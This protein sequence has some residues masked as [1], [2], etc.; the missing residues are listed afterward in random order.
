[1]RNYRK[2]NKR[3]R[4]GTLDLISL[5]LGALLPLAFAP[6]NIYPIAILV[7]GALLFIWNNPNPKRVLWRGWL[8]GCGFFGV[9]ASWIFVS[10]HVYGNASVWLAGL[11]TLLFVAFLALY[12]ATQAWVYK[13]LFP[14]AGVFAWTIGFAAIWALWEWLRG[15]LFSG[16]PW[17]YLGYSQMDSPLGGF[18]P[19]IGIYG[20]TALAA[21]VGG[22]LAY[23]LYIQ[24]K[25]RWLCLSLAAL[26]LLSGFALHFIQW[27]TSTNLPKQVSLIQGNI[28]QAQKWDRKFIQSIINRYHGLTLQHEDSA[29]I[30]WPE[31]SLP[32]PLPDSAPLVATFADEAKQR[33]NTLILGALEFSGDGDRFYNSVLAVGTGSGVYHKRQLVP[34]GEYIP[35]ESLLRNVIEFF[36]L[37]SSY[38]ES[39]AALQPVLVSDDWNIAPLICYEIAY[40]ALGREAALQGNITLTISNDTWFGRSLGPKQHLQIAQFRALETGRYVMRATNN[41][42]TAIINQ[43]GKIT[44]ITPAFETNVLTAEAQSTSGLTP[45]VRIGHLPIIFILLILIGIAWY[46]NKRKS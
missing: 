4:A 16:F 9:G 40:A 39:G 6:F 38:T 26:L 11:L 3:F 30:I 21:S 23:A 13:R 33:H 8:F 35:F 36:N 34:F 5:L 17:L 43:Q 2:V 19:V 22:L 10:I 45:I 44:A 12:P 1:M 29:I 15:W 27:T 20:T 14:K 37:P 28:P 18:I 25:I 31:A 24:S 7:P 41:G 32:I 46:T 42:I